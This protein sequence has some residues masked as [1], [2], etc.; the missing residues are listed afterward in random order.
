MTCDCM[1]PVQR[2]IMWRE[3]NIDLDEYLNILH[4]FITES[5]HP[6]NLNLRNKDTYDQTIH[7]AY[8]CII[9]D[10]FIKPCKRVTTK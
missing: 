4:W 9:C 2:Q 3:V 8:L 6:G 5:G 1:T 7:R 10:C